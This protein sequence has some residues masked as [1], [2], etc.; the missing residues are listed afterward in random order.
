MPRTATITIDDVPDELIEIILRS[1][2]DTFPAETWRDFETMYTARNTLSLVC[3]R[4]HQIVTSIPQ[5]WSYLQI[6][7][8]RQ[9]PSLALV[10]LWIHRAGSVPMNILVSGERGPSQDR[11][12]YISNVF[13]TILRLRPSWRMLIL[14]IGVPLDIFLPRIPLEESDGLRAIKLVVNV[15]NAIGLG[16]LVDNVL[17]APFLRRLTL[18]CAPLQKIFSSAYL[19]RFTR[20]THFTIVT[21][22]ISASQLVALLRLCASAVMID[23]T[24]QECTEHAAQ[25]E[26]EEIISNLHLRILNLDINGM[27]YEIFRHFN[28]PNLE[29]LHHGE[30]FSALPLAQRSLRPFEEWLRHSNHSLRILRLRN[31]NMM[32]QHANV[33]ASPELEQIPIV[34][35]QVVNKDDEVLPSFEDRMVGGIHVMKLPNL[36]DPTVMS[37]GWVLPGAYAMMDDSD[38]LPWGPEIYLFVVFGR[39]MWIAAAELAREDSP[40]SSWGIGIIFNAFRSVTGGK[41]DEEIRRAQEATASRSQPSIWG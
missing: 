28:F 9:S 21:A 14:D 2:M 7:L 11:Q 20:L 5:I 41:V 33:L 38:L 37:I 18:E 27:G 36:S 26:T 35:I 17:A 10:I 22:D 8:D 31:V 39:M 12:R 3:R 19:A 23:I 15:Y 40:A 25:L 29:V 13:Y 6:N 24:A 1:H 34:E 32:S 30:Y 4:W 16:V